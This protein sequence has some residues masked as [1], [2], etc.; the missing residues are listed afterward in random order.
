MISREG[1]DT[2]HAVVQA[3]LHGEKPSFLSTIF[4]EPPMEDSDKDGPCDLRLENGVAW[5]RIEGPIG[6]K[7]SLLEKVSG[8]TDIDDLRENID[9]AKTNPDVQAICFEVDSP[10]GSV[11]GVPDLAEYIAKVNNE[12]MPCYA[13]IDEMC[14]SAAY[15]LVAGCSEIL[16]V[17]RTSYCGSIG[18]Y[19]YVLDSTRQYK[20]EGLDPILIKAGKN[21][22]ELLPGMPIDDEAKARMQKEVDYIYEM[23]SG[24]VSKCRPH[25]T[26]DSMQGHGY[27]AE[28]AL[29]LG[30]ID[31]IISN[32]NELFPKD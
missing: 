21:K 19:S 1:F 12:E 26:S 2:V 28:E 22:G 11:S 14:C 17:G 18:V 25:V 5:I 23:F 24:H 7:L 31:G 6:R 13:L 30:L 20:E 27:F 8:V 16:A 29:K 10:G 3:K 4:A 32:R 9:I 15:Y